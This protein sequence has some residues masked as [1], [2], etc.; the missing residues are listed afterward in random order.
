MIVPRSRSGLKEPPVENI[1]KGLRE[2]RFG[3][4]LG[5][6]RPLAALLGSQRAAVDFPKASTAAR[7]T[8]KLGASARAEGGRVGGEA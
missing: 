4:S 8:A 1:G 5:R 2:R 6:S 3:G 7:I